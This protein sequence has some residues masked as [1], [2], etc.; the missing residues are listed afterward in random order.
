MD[1]IWLSVGWWDNIK[2]VVVI[3]YYYEKVWCGVR[4]LEEGGRG[5]LFGVG[6]R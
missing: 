3:E 1:G 2:T 6:D 4:W 5:V